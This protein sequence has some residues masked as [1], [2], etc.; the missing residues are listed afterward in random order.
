MVVGMQAERANPLP[1]R[2]TSLYVPNDSPLVGSRHVSLHRV[3]NSS[4]RF[5]AVP[6]TRRGLTANPD[7]SYL[8]KNRI[9]QGVKIESRSIAKIRRM[10]LQEEIHTF[11]PL[12][13]QHA[14]KLPLCVELG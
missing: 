2:S 7:I 5:K 3:T 10:I 12:L 8:L 11:T 4:S 9:E 1:S 6:R 14:E 13:S